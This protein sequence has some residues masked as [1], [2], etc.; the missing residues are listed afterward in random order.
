FEVAGVHSGDVSWGHRF[1][2]VELPIE[3]PGEGAEGAHEVR[4]PRADAYL[5]RMQA[6]RVVVDPEER[7]RRIV[8]G[9]NALAAPE[10][11]QV[12][13]DEGLL[14]DVVFTVEYPTPF[15][16]RFD[17]E[18]LRLPRPVLVSAMRKH[19]RYF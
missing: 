4:V 2:P 14:H 15:L 8:E 1:L 17:E 12:V 19:Q 13:W 9:G 18:Y 5:E 6:A 11:I 7:R 3:L 10:R 16:G